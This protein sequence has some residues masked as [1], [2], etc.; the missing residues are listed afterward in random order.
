VQQ[1]PETKKK[2]IQGSKS[3]ARVRLPRDRVAAALSPGLKGERYSF[4]P[5]K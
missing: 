3:P 4:I 5:T 1:Q 2:R